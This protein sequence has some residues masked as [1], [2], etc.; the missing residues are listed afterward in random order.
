MK[1]VICAA[2]KSEFRNDHYNFPTLYT[3]IGKINATFS[4]TRYLFENVG[5]VDTVI[6]VGSAGGIY[7]EQ[8]RRVIECGIFS[9]GDLDYPNYKKIN[10][11]NWRSTIRIC[12]FDRF[13]TKKPEEFCHAVDM[14]SYALAK[15]CRDLNVKFYC[16][17]YITDI[18][19][20]GGQEEEWLEEHH[21][22]DVRLKDAID[23]FLQNTNK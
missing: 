6:N 2:I 12:T 5:K 20:Y 23:E 10:I 8:K 4:L 7:P 14:E 16:F 18:V 22:G 17:K 9:D 11:C 13:Q 15:V 1:P 21:L 3:G 19:G